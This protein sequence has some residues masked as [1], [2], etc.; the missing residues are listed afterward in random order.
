M[1]LIHQL[2]L[3]SLFFIVNTL[4]MQIIIL[5]S[6]TKIDK[7]TEAILHNEK[8]TLPSQYALM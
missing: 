5:I 2:L 1:P 3:F 4:F 7:T 8:L 6:I